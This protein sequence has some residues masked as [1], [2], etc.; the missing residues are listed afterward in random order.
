MEN[1]NYTAPDIGNLTFIAPY[2]E[3]ISYTSPDIV[4]LT[5]TAQD[6]N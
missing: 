2:M 1:L 6:K 5:Y 4:N 3:H